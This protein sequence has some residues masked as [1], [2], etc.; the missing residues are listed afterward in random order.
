MTHAMKLA[1]GTAFPAITAPRLG[2]GDIALAAMQGW[3]PLVIYRRKHCP[4][5]KPYLANLDKLLG[6]FAAAGIAVMAVSADPEEKAA[7]DH[8]ESVGAFRSASGS[9]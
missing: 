7:A 8:A 4:L 9:A 5:C 3:R 6:E 1:A 2:G